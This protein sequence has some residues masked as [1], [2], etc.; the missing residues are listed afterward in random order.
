MNPSQQQNYFP[1][2]TPGY[3][4][5]HS[6]PME[7]R[8]VGGML[9]PS[10]WENRHL[11]VNAHNP[12]PLAQGPMQTWTV[13][14]QGT[15]TPT[16]YATQS[17]HRQVAFPQNQPTVHPSRSTLG[18]QPYDVVNPSPSTIIHPSLR[19][20]PA[21]TRADPQ[22]QITTDDLL[23]ASIFP[24]PIRQN[25]QLPP[26]MSKQQGKRAIRP[27]AGKTKAKNIYLPN[28][29]SSVNV[30]NA[31]HNHK[32]NI[33][34]L[35]GREDV[36]IEMRALI[37]KM[38]DLGD[39]QTLSEDDVET[40]EALYCIFHEAEQSFQ[41]LNRQDRKDAVIAHLQNFQKDTYQAFGILLTATILV[42]EDNSSPP[43]AILSETK[44]RGCPAFG[45][46]LKKRHP[47]AAA[48]ERKHRIEYAEFAFS[49]RDAAKGHDNRED[50][51]DDASENEGNNE[52][53]NR[54]KSSTRRSEDK[55]E[56][57]GRHKRANHDLESDDE[58]VFKGFTKKGDRL[59]TDIRV[60]DLQ[61]GIRIFSGLGRL[62]NTTPGINVDQRI[63]YDE[64][65]YDRMQAMGYPA[66]SF[67]WKRWNS[68]PDKYLLSEH[69][70]TL[71]GFRVTFGPSHSTNQEEL[72]CW[73]RFLLT[74]KIIEQMRLRGGMVWCS[75]G[76]RW[77][78]KLASDSHFVLNIHANNYIEDN[79]NQRIESASN[80]RPDNVASVLPVGTSPP[81]EDL[82]PLA[83]SSADALDTASRLALGVD[84]VSEPTGQA[85]TTGKDQGGGEHLSVGH[86]P[87][88]EDNN[89]SNE[90]RIHT[91]P[92]G[93][94]SGRYTKKAAINEGE[95]NKSK[96]IPPNSR[97][98]P[99]RGVKRKDDNLTVEEETH[100][101]DVRRSSRSTKKVR[102]D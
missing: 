81:A 54:R 84:Q 49:M 28:S 102:R 72:A 51:S 98:R 77:L 74:T 99:D 45:E 97:N 76:L 57:R 56:Y 19:P 30:W 78:S 55:D 65:L 18:S 69:F 24:H 23:P 35:V 53:T 63:M 13:S 10:T 42:P 61:D 12:N 4:L 68:D 39:Y 88:P 11:P 58:I 94:K 92:K 46:W 25:T 90:E 50:Q 44:P 73:L 14:R 67:N 89:Q 59:P 100:G 5:Q 17:A 79:P 75:N 32:G 64:L 40:W 7:H 60:V 83:I 37:E 16:H 62:C 27:V 82:N 66:R 52:G 3:P 36:T 2:N 71:H 87:P 101:S 70:P 6:Q 15:A 86:C 95:G 91:A 47:N 93:K 33:R 80:N 41:F 38:S 85:S 29:K 21:P 31:R 22:A 96:I 43:E 9:V 34:K 26:R 8:P 1:Q 48:E 20:S